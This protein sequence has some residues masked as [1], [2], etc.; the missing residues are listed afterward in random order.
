MRLS[1]PLAAVVLVAVVLALSVRSAADPPVVVRAARMLDVESGRMLADAVVVVEGEWI[2]AVNPAELPEGA[3][4]IDLGDRTLLPGLIDLHVHLT[5][6]LEEGFVYRAVTDTAA[7]AAFRAAANARKTL[8]AGFTTVREAGSDDFVDVALGEAIDRGL[9]EGPRVVP[10]GHSLGITG[11]HC[12]VTG[13]APGI[14]EQ[15][16]E[17][18]VVDGPWEAVEAVRYQ[19][20]H[21]ARWIK[22]CAT[23]GVL[24]LEGPVGAQQLSDE[25]MRAIVEEAAR[26]GVKVAAHAHGTEGILAAVRAGVA[27]IE[28]GSMLTDEAIALMKERGTYL[29]PTTYLADAIDLEVLPPP[30]RAKAESVLPLAK[31]SVRRAIA[32]GVPIAFGTDA[33]VYPHGDNAR[34]LATLVERGMTPLEALR[35]ATVHAAALLGA[36]DRGAIA[37]GRLADLVAVDGDPLADVTTTERVRFVMKGGVVYKAP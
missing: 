24:S 11:G 17:T 27:S 16:P 31:E 15:G 29:V 10:V 33:A 6:Q 14:L 21:G 28:H 18:G 7:D 22:I 25:E 12:D 3:E 23:A 9:V 32:A 8:M 2:A 1:R 19:I 13:F 30:I 35:T 5:S 20:K 36:D 4:V 37:A 26:H 34:E